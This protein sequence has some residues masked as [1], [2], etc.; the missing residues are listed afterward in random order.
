MAVDTKLQTTDGQ[1]VSAANP[2]PTSG[3]GL[4]PVGSHTRNASL[5][6]AVT[7]TKP[8]TA[9]RLL[10]QCETQNV[11]FTLDGTAPTATTGFLLVA[12]DP[13]ILIPVGGTAV[14]VI[15]VAASASIN[16]QWGY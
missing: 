12:S 8:A 16:Y 6:S 2:L 9:T 5:S 14:K 1:R 11:K 13:A 4:T 3:A 7:L 15:E 10:I